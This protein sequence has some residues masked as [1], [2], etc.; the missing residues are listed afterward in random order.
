[1]G[2]VEV[3]AD[4]VIVDL[5]SKELYPDFKSVKLED[6]LQTVLNGKA[7]TIYDEMVAQLRA[8]LGKH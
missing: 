4:K 7:K 8:G 2:V 6:Y 3:Y 1:M 5:T